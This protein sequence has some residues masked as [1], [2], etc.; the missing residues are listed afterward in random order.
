MEKND[1]N[2]AKSK[3]TDAERMREFFPMRVRTSAFNFLENGSLTLKD[4]SVV[5][6]N[7]RCYRNNGI[8]LSGGSITDSA[9]RMTWRL[10]N[11]VCPEN[12]P[13]RGFP[14]DFPISFVA[15]PI[16]DKPGYIT[17]KFM[18]Q[19][20]PNDVTIEVYSWDKQGEPA[21]SMPF[22]WR[23]RIPLTLIIT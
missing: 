23:C 4:D 21:P 14:I 17:V 2:T 11:F 5:I 19:P 3:E 15:T 16:T 13:Q 8:D 10:L 12:I 22:Y 1:A 20:Q 18:P 9:G 7:P 6:N